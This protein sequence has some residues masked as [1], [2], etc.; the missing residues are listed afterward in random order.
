[1]SSGYFSYFQDKWTTPPAPS[2]GTF[3][4]PMAVALWDGLETSTDVVQPLLVYG[5]ITSSNCDDGWQFTA[6]ALFGSTPY[7]AT[8]YVASSGDSIEGTITYESSYAGCTNSGPAYYIEAV[9]TTASQGSY[10]TECTSDHYSVA[11]AGSIE[12]HDLST[13]CTVMPGTGSDSFGSLSW[14]GTISPT[15][16]EATGSQVSFCSAAASW[17]SSA[18]GLSWTDT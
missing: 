1:M 8:S 9:D 10:L 4:Y 18:L 7:Y 15:V 6:S 12:I 16:T 5:C 3:T 11:V 17:G 13:P 14:T 2:S